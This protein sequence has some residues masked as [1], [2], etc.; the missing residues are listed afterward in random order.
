LVWFGVVVCAIFGTACMWLASKARA[1]HMQM[2]RR[3]RMHSRT[4]GLED[5]RRKWLAG[6]VG[7]TIRA[8][9]CVSCQSSVH[10]FS[11]LLPS[12]CKPTFS[13]TDCTVLHCTTATTATPPSSVL[14]CACAVGPKTKDDDTSV[15]LDLW[16]HRLWTKRIKPGFDLSSTASLALALALACLLA[17][18]PAC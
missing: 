5:E 18:L 15:S 17:A 12:A 1:C 2:S 7:A 10:Q 16:A 4:R 13:S 6:S 9:D 8:F 14:A 11:S 3:S